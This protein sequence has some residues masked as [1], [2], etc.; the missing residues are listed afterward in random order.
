MT[1]K[2]KLAACGIDCHECA[3]YKVT[4][5]QDL[6]SAELM[7][8]WF[9]SQ[10]LIGE[11]EGAEA[12]VKKAPFCTGCWKIAGDCYWTGCN[13]CHFRAC[14]VEKQIDHCGYCND[15]PCER[16]ERW[17]STGEFYK[18]AMDFLFSFRQAST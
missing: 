3:S 4:T 2:M 17:A 8:P 18:K 10:K 5:E 15:F 9:R 6:K 11:D 12:I 16:Y 7:L 14:C 13:S 1:E